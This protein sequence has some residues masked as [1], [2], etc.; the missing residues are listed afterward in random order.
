M[1]FITANER[2]TLIVQK[3][4]LVFNR[5]VPIKHSDRKAGNNTRPPMGLQ[6]IICCFFQ[7]HGF[8]KRYHIMT[9]IHLPTILKFLIYNKNLDK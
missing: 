9:L 6:L 1:S 2:D 5:K 7:L 4:P 8:A 3:N